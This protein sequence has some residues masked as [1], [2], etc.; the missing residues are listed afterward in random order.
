VS[1]IE[2]AERCAATGSDYLAEGLFWEAAHQFTTALDFIAGLAGKEI[3]EKRVQWL[4]LRGDARH[5]RQWFAL[6]IEDYEQVLTLSP[7]KAGVAE[8]IHAVA[9]EGVN[10]DPDLAKYLGDSHGQ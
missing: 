7:G 3:E 8:K 6:A 9:R 2:K 10:F 4:T 5:G 1:E